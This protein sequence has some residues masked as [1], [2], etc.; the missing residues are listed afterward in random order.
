MRTFKA[1][2]YDHEEDVFKKKKLSE[3]WTQIG[4]HIVQRD[5]YSAFLLEHANEEFTLSDKEQCKKEFQ[6]FLKKHNK[7]I[8]TLKIER[9]EKV[10]PSSVGL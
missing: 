3:R 1:S 2:Q 7:V 10:L 6:P 9:K 8:H 5:M 4:K